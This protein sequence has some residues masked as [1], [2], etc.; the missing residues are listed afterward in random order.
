M[1]KKFFRMVSLHRTIKMT[2][3]D[4][5]KPKGLLHLTQIIKFKSLNSTMN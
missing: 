4:S 1:R 5:I 2:L 3:K